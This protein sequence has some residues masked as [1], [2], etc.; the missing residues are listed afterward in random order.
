MS[1]AEKHDEYS[2]QWCFIVLLLHMDK[3]L[4][5]WQYAIRELC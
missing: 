3:T 4:H 1:V 2:A 5:A